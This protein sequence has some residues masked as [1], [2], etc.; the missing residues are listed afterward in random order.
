MTGVA[1]AGT[2]DAAQYQYA[3][4]IR[5]GIQGSADITWTKSAYR[6]A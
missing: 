2:V 1:S 3:S 6:I 4:T 5:H